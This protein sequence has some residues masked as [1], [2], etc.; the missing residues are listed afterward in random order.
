[1]ARKQ[2]ISIEQ[3]TISFR[4]METGEKEFTQIKAEG[5]NSYYIY[6]LWL[7]GAVWDEFEKSIMDG[8]QSGTIG[9]PLPMLHMMIER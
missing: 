3:L 5:T 2:R 9:T 1:M 7:Y 6:G 8:A 4:I